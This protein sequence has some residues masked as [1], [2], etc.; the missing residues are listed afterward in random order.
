MKLQ[1]IQI[2]RG[3]AA[4]L[5][6]LY[7]IR[8]QEVL[9]IGGN[10][11]AEMPFLNGFVN[12]GFAG[13][14]LFFV[15]SG[16]IM[17][18]VTEGD[19]AGVRTAADFLFGRLTRIYPIW[20]FF[21]G[22]MTL[23]L[24]GFHGTIGVGERWQSFLHSEAFAPYLL[25]SF[26]LL[27]QKDDP[28]LGVGWTLVHEVY[29]YLVFTLILLAKRSWLPLFLLAWGLLVIGGWSLGLSGPRPVDIPAL[30]FFPMT[31][32][33]IMGAA[34]GMLVCSGL[35][36]RAGTITLLAV[37][38]LGASLCIQGEITTHTLQW[39]RVMLYGFPSAA[40][41]YGVVM[42]ERTRRLSWLVPA[43]VLFL[44]TLLVYQLYGTGDDTPFPLRLGGTIVASSVGVL[45]ML[46]TFWAGWYGGQTYP[47][48]IR[49]IIPSLSRIR[50]A[51]VR[52]GDASYSLYL[53]HTLFIVAMRIAF[54]ALGQIEPLAPLFSLGNPGL[55]DNVIFVAVCLA[56]SIT[57]SLLSYRFIERP[58]T[59]GFRH[60][61]SRLFDQPGPR[62]GAP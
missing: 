57:G 34:T 14:D 45:A 50:R 25:K 38:A 61:R 36:W 2:L 41:I 7:H 8:A 5:V 23:Y 60:L 1:S 6:V 49:A 51:F 56:V 12:N 54:N 43:A 33:F 4:L 39:G 17:V 10:G 40:L 20:W 55:L 13:V 46:A 19:K 37:V 22:I 27:P 32:E 58:M 44:V 48:A 53:S 3:I 31:M 15:I 35:A 47:D 52:L 11:L 26:L 9:A 59:H 28:V 21:A 29:F 62:A 16:F 18:V 24:V 30:V 42:L